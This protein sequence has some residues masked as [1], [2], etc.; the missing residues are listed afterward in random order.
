MSSN[1]AGN[2]IEYRVAVKVINDDKEFEDWGVKD[3][4]DP[5]THALFLLAFGNGLI[6][7]MRVVAETKGSGVEIPPFGAS[8]RFSWLAEVGMTVYGFP[9]Q[10]G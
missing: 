5:T 6:E 2:I 8:R 10:G 4:R 9:R 1:V 3:L 7:E